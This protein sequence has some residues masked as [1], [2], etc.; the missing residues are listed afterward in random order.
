MRAALHNTL[1]MTQRKTVNLRGEDEDVIRPFLSDGPERAE[2]ARM[3]G[4][5]ATLYSDSA[6]LRA[7]AVLGARAVKERIAERGYE[8]LAAAYTEEDRTA[9]EAS[10][11]TAAEAW[12][13]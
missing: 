9:A 2:L 7:L 6:A 11:E 5:E 4:E 12:V 13:E 1:H 8:S 3:V 10:L